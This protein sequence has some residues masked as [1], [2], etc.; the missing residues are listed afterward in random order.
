MDQSTRGWF[1]WKTNLF[2]SHIS[3][4]CTNLALSHNLTHSQSLTHT[5]TLSPSGADLA[6]WPLGHCLHWWQVSALQ[7]EIQ[8]R[9]EGYSKVVWKV[10]SE[11][12]WILLR[13]LFRPK[14]VL[15]DFPINKKTLHDINHWNQVALIEK[16]YAK[17]HGSY[18]VNINWAFISYQGSCLK[19]PKQNIQKYFFEA[20]E[21]GMPIEA[22]VDLTGGLAER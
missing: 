14:G 4:Y 13:S 16:A 3:E 12:G 1:R 18:E 5:R 10:A 9:Q 19:C 6:L 17:I 15:G 11:K 20:I 7:F 22:M 2:L 21:G 8:K